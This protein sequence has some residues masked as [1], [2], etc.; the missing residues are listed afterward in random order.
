MTNIGDSVYFAIDECVYIHR[1]GQKK[2]Y[3]RGDDSPM[4]D[5]I[6][7]CLKAAQIRKTEVDVNGT[8][9][10]SVKNCLVFTT[11]RNELVSLD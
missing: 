9:S 6:I 8:E 7:T 3:P 2:I 10:C 5:N 4:K 11:K 1:N